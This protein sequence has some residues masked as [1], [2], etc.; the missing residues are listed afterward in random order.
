M[1][2]PASNHDHPQPSP[3]SELP[4]WLFLLSFTITNQPFRV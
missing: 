2:F 1:G 4:G 3:H